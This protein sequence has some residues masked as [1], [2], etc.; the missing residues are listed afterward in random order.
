M[1]LTDLCTDKVLEVCDEMLLALHTKNKD[2]QMTYTQVL[3]AYGVYKNRWGDVCTEVEGICKK[4]EEKKQLKF[5][6]KINPKTTELFKSMTTV[7]KPLLGKAQSGT[8]HVKQIISV[9]VNNCLV[10][11]YHID[12]ELWSHCDAK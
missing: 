11:F 10:W 12:T 8:V 6:K 7:I 5:N 2:K 9:I 3:T 4:M 1:N